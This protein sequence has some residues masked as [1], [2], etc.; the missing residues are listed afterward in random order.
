VTGSCHSTADSTTTKDGAV[1]SRMDAAARE[2]ICWQE[3]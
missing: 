3:K 1:Y 2:Q